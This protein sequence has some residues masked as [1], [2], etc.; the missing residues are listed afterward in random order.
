MELSFRVGYHESP[1]MQAA[2]EPTNAPFF[3]A[4]SFISSSPIAFGA[5]CRLTWH[6]CAQNWEQMGQMIPSSVAEEL[7]PVSIFRLLAEES[8]PDIRE[9]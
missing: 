8:P 1:A 7:L 2:A 3:S 6:A 4:M 5:K 9:Y